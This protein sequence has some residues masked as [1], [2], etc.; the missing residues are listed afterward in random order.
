MSTTTTL[1][2][3]GWSGDP[4]TKDDFLTFVQM[5]VVPHGAFAYRVYD[6]EE[7]NMHNNFPLAWAVHCDLE[8]KR[9]SRSGFTAS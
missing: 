7:A 9:L 2:S 5:S 4:A 6:G 8:Q 1:P 3:A